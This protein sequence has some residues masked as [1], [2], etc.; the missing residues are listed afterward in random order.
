MSTKN[1]LGKLYDQLTPE[2]RFRLDVL[3]M[4]RGDKEE[5]EL[6]VRTCPRH[7]YTMN[8]RGFTGRWLGAMD[9]TLRT[10]IDVAGYL[11]RIKTMEMVRVILP[12]SETFAGDRAYEVYLDGHRAG[13]RQAWRVAGKEGEVPEWP[14]ERVDEEGIRENIK[15]A[16][17]ILPQTLEA[18]E[19]Q[20]AE[21]ALTLWR[22]FEAFC[23]E[24]M[25]V[26]AL[27]LLKV[28]LEAGVEQIEELEDLARSLEL[29]PHA[30]TVEEIR[31]GLAE[32]WQMV[33]KRGS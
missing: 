16:T 5:S 30:E 4:A 7:N 24:S 19:R 32:A 25:G 14:L 33:E 15:L 31:E 17:S 12:Y 22:G 1:G 28:V 29:E 9:I 10:F 20:Q 26:E 8:H 13:A 23:E 3:A 11:N 6:L 18:L 27:A 2:E 21:H